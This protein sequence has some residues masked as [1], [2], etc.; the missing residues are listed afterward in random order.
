MKAAL[1]AL[2]LFAAPAAARAA[3]DGAALAAR[4]ERLAAELDELARHIE[5]RKAEGARNG[6]LEAL[7]RRSQALARELAGLERTLGVP[8]AAPGI[9]SVDL[10]G[11]EVEDP[12]EA[13]ERADLLRDQRDRV[14]DELRTVGARLEEARAEEALAR[15]LRDF[16]DEAELFDDASRMMRLRRTERRATAGNDPPA[17]GGEGTEAP[18]GADAEAAPPPGNIGSDG[19]GFFG[20]LEAAS[21][22]PGAAPPLPGRQD[23]APIEAPQP[24]A[25]APGATPPGPSAPTYLQRAGR[26][27]LGSDEGGVLGFAPLEGDESVA[28]LERRREALQRL[29]DELE[30]RAAILEEASRSLAAPP[31][32]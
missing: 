17:N 18:A 15:E 8:A 29:A 28:E 14:L 24:P 31:A 20:G 3:E 4:R 5:R 7:L 25:A 6:E 2:L 12:D 30:R 32:P 9:L 1:L 27:P 11:L 19:E 10:G 16:V 23:P 13:R 21:D 26:R 22:F